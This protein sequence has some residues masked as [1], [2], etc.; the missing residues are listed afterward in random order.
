MSRDGEAV[1]RLVLASASP[2][3]L[4]LLRLI[5]IEPVVVP[6]DVDETAV[7]G[8]KPE[9]LVRRLATTKAQHVAATL[10]DPTDSFVLG[11]DTF[12]LG[13][14][15]VIDLDGEILGKPVDS[16][17]AARMLQAL[18]GRSHLVLT[19]IAL[20]QQ[21]AG[22]TTT[23]VMVDSTEVWMRPYTEADIDWYVASGEPLG[24][25]GAYAIQGKGSLLVERIAGSYQNVVGLSLPAV[26]ELTA[27]FGRD[28]RSL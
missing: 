24:K 12:V 11:A 17:D 21:T 8:E 26:H 25:A 22:G 4:D 3:R 7:V 14:D 6:A 10:D 27:R 20:V 2:R 1:V 18:A 5:G 28:L 15:T 19:G 23:E 16:A 9:D 13:A